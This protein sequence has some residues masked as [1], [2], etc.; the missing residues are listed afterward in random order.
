MSKTRWAELSTE[1]LEAVADKINRLLCDPG[2]VCWLEK[3]NE[4][5][6]N[7]LF[8]VLASVQTTSLGEGIERWRRISEKQFCSTVDLGPYAPLVAALEDYQRLERTWKG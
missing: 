1:K 4:A 6:E 8:A 5:L 7:I 3:R 2:Y